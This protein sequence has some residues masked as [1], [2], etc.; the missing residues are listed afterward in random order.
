[1]YLL[2]QARRYGAVP[3]SI[4]MYP[5]KGRN[6]QH[7]S[8]VA[9][10]LFQQTVLMLRSVLTNAGSRGRDAHHRC[11]GLSPLSMFGSLC[12]GHSERPLRWGRKRWC[13]SSGN[14]APGTTYFLHAVCHP[15][16]YLHICLTNQRC[17]ARN[18]TSGSGSRWLILDSLL[19]VVLSFFFSGNFH[20]PKGPRQ[21]TY[22]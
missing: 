7:R 13:P 9:W 1:M 17:H 19:A 2:G 11:T 16:P 18:K 14:I 15:P 20:L 10:R 4:G 12:I 3:D 6:C 22:R 8:F 21:G 5:W